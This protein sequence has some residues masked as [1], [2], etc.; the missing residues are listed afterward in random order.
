VIK[1]TVIGSGNVGSHLINIFHNS[2]NVEL[3]EWYSK[4]LDYDE[5]VNIIN[6]VK[7]LSISD[8]YILCVNDDSISEISKK[9][10][11]KNK[12][13]L[14]TSGSSPFQAI[15]P[16]NKRGIFYPLQTF[17]K[18]IELD[19]SKIPICLETEDLKDLKKLKR[20]VDGIGCKYHEVNY[21]QRKTLHLAAVITNNFTNF[22]FGL[23]KELVEKKNL[24]FDILK[25]LINET[26]NK[27]HK[28]DPIDAQ[29]GPARRND[30]NI[31][32]IHVDMFENENQKVLYQTISKMI[33]DRYEN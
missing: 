29:T 6:D 3:N 10:P 31:L 32:N 1:V 33:K 12:L 4:S 22:L 16:K 14:H 18:D 30:K 28:L 19:Y 20:L 11:F 17:T 5:R 23:S 27:I 24:D 21:D 26:V 8:V 15:N 13:V 9:L 25:P 7:K 2:A